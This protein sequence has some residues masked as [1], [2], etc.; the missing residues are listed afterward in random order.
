[1]S[2]AVVRAKRLPW[3]VEVGREVNDDFIRIVRLY[4]IEQFKTDFSKEN[5]FEACMTLA[6]MC[7]FNPV[8]EYLDELE[9][10]KT[11]RLDTWLIDY[12]G[13]EDVPL[14]REIGRLV[15]IAAVRRARKPGT[16][17][18]QVLILEGMQ[19]SGKSSA[20]QIL[21]GEWHSDADLGRVDTKEASIVLQGCWI[22]ELGEMTAMGRSEIESLKAFLS[23]NVDRYRAPF[24]RALKSVP[25]RCLFIG[26]TNSGAY[27]RDTTGN[28]RF[29]PV[30]TDK[31]DLEGLKADRDQLWAEAAVAEAAGESL[32]L[33]PAL[34][35]DASDVQQSRLINDPWADHLTDFLKRSED[36]RVHT[37]TLLYDLSIQAG[38]QTPSHA[39]RLREAMASLG[40]KYK[41]SIRIGT[42]NRAG[43]EAPDGW[44]STATDVGDQS[45]F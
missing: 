42:D 23:R 44:T 41:R 14:N 43:Y 9:W 18:D 29:W 39:K 36:R 25:R 30:R 2:R 3:D 27:L 13:A 32:A 21:G 19:G 12:L 17:F 1:L 10:D 20:L 22:F 24:E 7:P 34:R 8:N 35:E 11:K 45:S 31:I 28:R 37:V 40:W 6:A 33:Q 38:Q 4:L 15:M 16:K 5:V 26:T